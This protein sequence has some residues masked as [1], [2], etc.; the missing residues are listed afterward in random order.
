ME[1]IMTRLKNYTLFSSVFF[2]LATIV[3]GAILLAIFPSTA[4]LS[5]GFQTPVIAFEFAKSESDLS[6]LSGNSELSQLNREKMDAGHSGWDMVFPFA[7]G[8][9]IALLL[10]RIK[11]QGSGFIWLG[12]VFA[13]LIIPFDINE[14]LTLLQITSALAD[15]ASTEGLLLA[16]YVATWLKWGAIGA[17][18]AILAAGYSINKNYWSATV[19][20]VAALGIATCWVFNSEPVLAETMSKLIFLFFVFFSIET[21]MQAWRLTQ[22][23][24]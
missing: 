19:S 5:E 13:V 23:K 7:Y 21:G 14:N 11:G 12:V 16:L 6:F 8:G 18:I 20:I 9:F 1:I 22:V 24:T 15:S 4:E 17:S 10:L 2:G 3:L